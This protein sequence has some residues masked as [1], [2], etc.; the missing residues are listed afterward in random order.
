MY[1]KPGRIEEE[2][3]VFFLYQLQLPAETYMK[4]ISASNFQLSRYL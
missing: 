2:S 3:P 4:D 1:M